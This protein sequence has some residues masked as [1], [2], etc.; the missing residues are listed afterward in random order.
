VIAARQGRG[1]VDEVPFFS[2]GLSVVSL[3]AALFLINIGMGL[4][5]IKN[6]KAAIAAGVALLAW[7]FVIVAMASTDKGWFK[8]GDLV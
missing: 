6:L 1:F 7:I 5:P 3:V 8:D 2:S 4:G